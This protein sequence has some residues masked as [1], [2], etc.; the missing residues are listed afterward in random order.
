MI[1]L[2]QG[3]LVVPAIISSFQAGVPVPPQLWELL[4]WALQPLTPLQ[5][6][7]CDLFSTSV[8]MW[9]LLTGQRLYAIP[10]IEW[11]PAASVP[12]KARKLFREFPI[13]DVWSH[14]SVD[15]TMDTLQ[16][17]LL[18]AS[19]EALAAATA[20]VELVV[21]G[22]HTCGAGVTL[23]QLQAAAETLWALLPSAERPAVADW[24]LGP[25][26]SDWAR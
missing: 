25:P 24:A 1:A 23:L 26:S 8:V 5:A 21:C 9:E 20:L 16:P 15:N 4:P 7:Q 17:L 18:G 6:T 12:K 13:L 11:T 22:L 19:H 2:K 3:D 14:I 10:G